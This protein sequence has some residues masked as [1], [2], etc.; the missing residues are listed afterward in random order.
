MVERSLRR[1][2]DYGIA[3][4]TAFQLFE[5]NV[6]RFLIISKT[7]NFPKI[8]QVNWNCVN[9]FDVDHIC[10]QTCCVE[11]TQW[12]FSNFMPT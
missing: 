6:V 12:H 10:Q 1:C 3:F 5:K 8:V 9:S 11:F 2:T 7:R 4:V